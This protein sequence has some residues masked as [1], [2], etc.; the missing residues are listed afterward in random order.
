MLKYLRT[1]MMALVMSG[2]VMLPTAAWA[3]DVTLIAA[4]QAPGNSP[5]EAGLEKFAELVSEKTKGAVEVDIFVGGQLG[6]EPE[7]FQGAIQGS[8]DVVIVAPGNIA[9]F[10]PQIAL[11]EMPFVT[12][13]HEQ[14]ERM[15]DGYPLEHLNDV[16]NEKT[17]TRIVGVFGGGTRNMFFT[18]PASGIEDFKGR[19]FRTQASKQLT[20]AYGALGLEPT[21][22][23]FSEM[24]GAL[25]QGVIE[26]GEMESIY[27]ESASFPEVAP[28]M[29]M[30]RHVITIRPLVMSDKTLAKLT[31][32]Q[33]AAVLEAAA[34][35][36][37]YER[38][39]EKTT[40]AE[41]LDRMKEKYGLTYLEVDVQPMIEAIRPVWEKYAAEWGEQKLLDSIE[42]LR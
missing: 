15:I 24:Y 16:L 20:D 36:S 21:V 38:G 40:D 31:D 34:E 5:F 12:T 8:V 4:T 33:R 27:T 9:E 41:A 39:I 29:L 11:L 13:S 42:E 23:A 18:E 32:E 25:Q 22:L 6:S 17:Q 30:T 28:N 35:A 2:A 26:G 19:R 14:V 10:V 7:L 3:A 37:E 1:P